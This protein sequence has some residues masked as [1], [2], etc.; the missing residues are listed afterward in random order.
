MRTR[1][2]DEDQ[3]EDQDEDEDEDEEVGGDCRSAGGH[4]DARHGRAAQASATGGRALE[5]D[6]RGGPGQTWLE[7]RTR[8]G[9]RHDEDQDGEETR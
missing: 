2:K 4:R 3:D 5:R 8:M 7:M 6:G 9:R 1:M